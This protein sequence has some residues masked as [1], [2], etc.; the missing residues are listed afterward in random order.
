MDSECGKAAQKLSEL[1][2]QLKEM[3]GRFRV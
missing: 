2:E 3:V 1:A